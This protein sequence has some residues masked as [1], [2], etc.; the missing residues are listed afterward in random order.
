[1]IA[2]MTRLL[3]GSTSDQPVSKNDEAG[4]DHAGRDGRVR[5]HVDE[6]APD[7]EI[8]FATADEKPGGETVDHNPEGCDPDDR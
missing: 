4:Y 6:S 2:T 5:R 7:V 3:I 8:A 1:M